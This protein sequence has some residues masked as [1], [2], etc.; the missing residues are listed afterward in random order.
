MSELSAIVPE[1]CTRRLLA[2]LVL[3]SQ[4]IS[5]IDTE[6]SFDHSYF[7]IVLVVDEQVLENSEEWYRLC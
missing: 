1:L 2:R 3:T 4:S 6:L 7:A 5:D